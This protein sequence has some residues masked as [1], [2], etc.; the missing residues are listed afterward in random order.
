LKIRFALVGKIP[1][2]LAGKKKFLPA[3]S[4]ETDS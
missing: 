4:A 3:K 1:A 2:L